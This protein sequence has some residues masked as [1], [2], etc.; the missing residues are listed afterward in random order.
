[1]SCIMSFVL[2]FNLLCFILNTDSNFRRE[3]NILKHIY[4][5][6]VTSFTESIL[7]SGRIVWFGAEPAVLEGSTQNLSYKGAPTIT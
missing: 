1:M 7:G 2:L 4:L 6:S 5:K 3:F